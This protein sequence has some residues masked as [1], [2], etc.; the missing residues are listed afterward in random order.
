VYAKPAV[1][2]LLDFNLRGGQEAPAAAA[3]AATVTE[4]YLTRT[5]KRDLTAVVTELVAWLGAGEPAPQTLRLE[6]SVTSTVVRVSVTAAHRKRRDQTL[7]SNESLRHTLPV[8]AA[9]A[10]RYGAEAN[11]RTRLWAEFDRHETDV[12]AY[13]QSQYS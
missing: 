9:L 1:I 5:G 12:P 4:R 2:E 3:R 6:L 13:G 11:G 10:S 7:A 8:T